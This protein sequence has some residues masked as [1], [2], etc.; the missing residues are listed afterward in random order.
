M[1]S[2]H[3]CPAVQTVPSTFAGFRFPPE[4]IVGTV[5]LMMSSTDH[6]AGGALLE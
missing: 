2:R 6:A 3:V 4:M 5:A 1:R